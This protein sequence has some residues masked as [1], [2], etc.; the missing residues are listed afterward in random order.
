[1][2]W[3]RRILLGGLVVGLILASHYFVQH[4]EASVA[5]HEKLGFARVAHLPE[6][7]WKLGR[8]IDVGYWQL[9]IPLKDPT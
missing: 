6:L 7:G 4:N 1:M 9:K 8:W 5:L 2:R 3:I